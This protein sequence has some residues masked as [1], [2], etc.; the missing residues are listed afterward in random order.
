MENEHRGGASARKLRQ[1][2]H[3]DGLNAI[4]AK[5]VYV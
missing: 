5:W 2:K 4:S 3:P 1:M